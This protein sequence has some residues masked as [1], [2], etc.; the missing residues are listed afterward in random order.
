MAAGEV[1]GEGI[2]TK[3]RRH[4]LPLRWLNC[5]G[6]A[7]GM[8]I[9]FVDL[10]CPWWAHLHHTFSCAMANSLKRRFVVEQCPSQ[11]LSVVV[12]C[13]ICAC[14]SRWARPTWGLSRNS[15]AMPPC[16]G[17]RKV[18]DAPPRRRTKEKKPGSPHSTGDR[19]HPHLGAGGFLLQK[20]GG[21]LHISGHHAPPP[22]QAH[23][24]TSGHDVQVQLSIQLQCKAVNQ[25]LL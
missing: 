23:L 17:S 16:K 11:S 24:H 10:L 20:S 18:A 4:R 25:S 14:R 3:D 5:L 13:L 15:W 7:A 9:L 2:A 21:V 19:S 8:R 1:N 6:V 22:Q 12:L